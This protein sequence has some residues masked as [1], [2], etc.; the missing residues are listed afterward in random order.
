MDFLLKS[1]K[2]VVEVKK[3]CRVLVDKEVGS[4]LL[5]DTLRYQNHQDCRHFVCFIYDPD[6]FINNPRRLEHDLSRSINGMPVKQ[7]VKQ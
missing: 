1:E 5:E 3:I 2:I 6:S 4:Q 7:P